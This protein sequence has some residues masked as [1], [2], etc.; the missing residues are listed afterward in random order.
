MKTRWM[1]RGLVVP[2]AVGVLMGPSDCD[3]GRGTDAREQA[4]ADGVDNDR[5]G[6]IDCADPDCRMTEL[7]SVTVYGV[8]FDDE[9]N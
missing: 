9:E 5:D 3:D 8:P 6:E 7:C 4:C 1:V 2:A